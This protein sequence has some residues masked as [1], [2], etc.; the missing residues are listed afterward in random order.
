MPF[1]LST[2]RVDKII[3]ALFGPD[4]HLGSRFGRFVVLLRNIDWLVQSRAFQ[5]VSASPTWRVDVWVADLRGYVAASKSTRKE[6]SVSTIGRAQFL[7]LLKTDEKTIYHSLIYGTNSFIG[8]FVLQDSHVR[9]HYDLTQ[10]IQRDNVWEFMVAKLVAVVGGAKSVLLI[11]VGLET[12][13]ISRAG[14][15]LKASLLTPSTASS[16]KRT[17]R[18]PWPT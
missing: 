11:G 9:T 4:A 10:Y 17:R 14:L 13:T 12:G 3:A 6:F 8:H 7:L 2:T 15:Q 18:F 5:V 16:E 1:H